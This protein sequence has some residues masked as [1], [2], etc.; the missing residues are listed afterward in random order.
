MSQVL[1][2]AYDYIVVGAGSAGCVLAG[3]LSEN[4]SVSV[5]LIEAG[6]SDSHPDVAD[7]AR[8]ARLLRTERAWQYET[9]PQRYCHNRIDRVRAG[10][11]SAVATA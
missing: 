5:L 11:C 2:K 8:W 6:G 4:A 10:R 9:V 3:R 7:P 1:E